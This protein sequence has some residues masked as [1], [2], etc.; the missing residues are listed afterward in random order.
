MEIHC[1]GYAERLLRLAELAINQTVDLAPN[2]STSQCRNQ[3]V[4]PSANQCTDE[5]IIQINASM[6]ESIDESISL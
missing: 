1:D 6:T 2:Q 3:S 4:K 5:L